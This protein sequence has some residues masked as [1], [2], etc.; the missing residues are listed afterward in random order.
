MFNEI[1]VNAT[2]EEIDLIVKNCKELLKC[3]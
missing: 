1:I 3:I 2:K